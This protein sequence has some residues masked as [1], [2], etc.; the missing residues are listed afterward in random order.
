MEVKRTEDEIRMI[1]IELNEVKRKIDVS[2]K[3]ILLV[4]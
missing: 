1:K 2:R 4:P 3:K